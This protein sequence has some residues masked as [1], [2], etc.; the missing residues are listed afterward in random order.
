MKGSSKYQRLYDITQVVMV[1][2]IVNAI[3]LSIN[4]QRH[5]LRVRGL[6]IGIV[7]CA[8][9]LLVARRKPNTSVN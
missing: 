5:M 8:I 2:F 9:I 6:C 3:I 4:L 7:L 1:I